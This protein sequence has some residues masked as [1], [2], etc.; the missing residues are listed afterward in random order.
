M[1][2]GIIFTGTGPILVLTTY[3]SFEDEQFVEKLARKGIMKF[4]AYELSL[5]LVRKKYGGQFQAI[6]NDVKQ[7]DDLRVLDYNGHN[8]FYNFS[9]KE[10]S[11]AITH[12]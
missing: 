4:I 7:E 5:D 12:E 6:V 2:A 1:K 9:F 10:M 11:P 3:S 8:V